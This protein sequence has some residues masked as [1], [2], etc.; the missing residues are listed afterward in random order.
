MP[1]AD[2]H[3]LASRQRAEHSDCPYARALRRRR[4]KRTAQREVIWD[5]LCRAGGHPTPEEL[6]AEALNLGHRLSMATIYR[7][8]KLFR[9]NGLVRRVEFGDGQSRY[10]RLKDAGRHL[11]LVCERCGRTLDVV[12]AAV[13]DRYRELA[14]AHAFSMRGQATCLYGIC[15]ACKEKTMTNWRDTHH[16]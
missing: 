5:V 16:D 7:T 11:H 14:E 4:F 10:E 3:S 13:T 2:D 8:L 6:F 12:D 9:L 1:S 15:D